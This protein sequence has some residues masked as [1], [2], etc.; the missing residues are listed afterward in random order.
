VLGDRIRVVLELGSDL[1]LVQG[2]ATQLEQVVMNLGLNAR[3][4]M[5]EG[6]TLTFRTCRSSEGWAAFSVQDTGVGIS[7]A[8]LD[9][10]WQPFFST[11]PPEDGVGL[12]LATSKEILRD[13][14]G[15]IQVESSQGLGSTFTVLLPP[16][17]V[18]NLDPALQDPARPRPSFDG[19]RILLA[20]DEPE[21]RMVLKELL[22]RMGAEVVVGVDG[23]DA[24]NLWELLG[25]FDLL[26][27]DQRMPRLNGLELIGRTRSRRND[28]PVLVMTGYGLEE[29]AV[30]LGGDR[31]AR[32]LAKPFTVPTLVEAI[33][34]LVNSPRVQP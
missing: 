17:P 25:P 18:Q 28:L 30:V 3:Q 22:T 10:I 12:G 7:P 32:L 13:H 14:G 9:R 23:E 5:S 31:R 20:E 2:N 15:R 8:L 11:R 33:T 4:A 19:L 26:V 6:G 16:S 1:P 27:T 24:W 21:I 34:S 29:A